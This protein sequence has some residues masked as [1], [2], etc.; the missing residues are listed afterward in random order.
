MTVD[1]RKFIWLVVIGLLIIVAVS[2]SF[3]YFTRPI[4][5]GAI[6]PINTSLGNEENLFTRYYKVKY[7]QIG[8]RPV[9][10]IIENPEATEA[11]VLKAYQRLNEQGVSA[12]IGGVL[13]QDGAWLADAAARTGIPTFGITSSS[14]LLSTKK[15]AFFRLVSTNATQAKAVGQFYQKLGLK[16]LALVTSVD[17]ITYVDPFVKVIKENFSAE[18]VQIPFA[19]AA[20]VSQKI[21]TANP[22]GVFTILAAK[23]VIQV[24]KVV[25][26]QRP[27]LPIGSSS[28]GS[29]E[30]LSLYSG[31]LLDGVLFF[32]LGLDVQGED[33]KAEIADFESK[34]SMKATNGSHYSASTLH[35]L[36]EA[37]QQVGDSRSAV[38]TYFE[39]PRAYDTCY[40]KLSMDEFGD[41]TTDR[42]TLL[43]TVNGV[44][45]TKEIIELK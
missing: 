10:F 4:L 21:S 30:I 18:I 13:S 9:K 45:N 7:P 39:T 37:I 17:N 42:V 3:W 12:I 25:R 31:P 22:D 16:R 15:D 35:M 28:W 6:L 32:S 5:I 27:D 2:I 38:K 8:L 19:S 44:M 41:G 40:G 29:V 1:R 43:Q 24:I 11:E 14:A 36:Y 23:D 26:D 34:Y 33:Y 20:E